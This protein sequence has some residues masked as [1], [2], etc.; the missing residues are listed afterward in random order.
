[1]KW[2]GILYINNNF[3]LNG[4]RFASMWSE[5]INKL[6]LNQHQL[7]K[8]I[9][10]YV[11]HSSKYHL[12]I[13]QFRQQ[14]PRH[15]HTIHYVQTL[16]FIYTHKKRSTYIHAICL[17]ILLGGIM[18]LMWVKKAQ[19][20]IKRYHHYQP[21]KIEYQTIMKDLA[22]G[23]EQEQCIQALAL[24]PTNYMIE[25]RTIAF[26]HNFERLGCKTLYKNALKAVL[27][28]EK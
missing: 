12:F 3:W 1:M 5:F 2:V 26:I 13:N 8:L 16:P 24:F 28:C 11:K 27:K 14:L 25:L 7:P 18:G 10:L 22:Q 19:Q 4:K 23:C 9:I 20:S 15:C 6:F 17:G 21:Y